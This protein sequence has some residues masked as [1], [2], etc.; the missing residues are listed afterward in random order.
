MGETVV[1][2]MLAL[3]DDPCTLHEVWCLRLRQHGWRSSDR[4]RF[5]DLVERVTGSDCAVCADCSDPVWADEV[6][7]VRGDGLVCES[8]VES[9]YSCQQCDELCHGDDMTSVRDGDYLVCGPCLRADWSYCEECEDYFA[10][11]SGHADEHHSG[12]ECESRHRCFHFPANGAGTV[13]NDTRL[14]VTL[15]SGV[16]D[17]TGLDAVNDYLC[18]A[19]IDPSDPWGDAA[20]QVRYLVRDVVE[21]VGPVWQTKQGNWPRR[22]SK[23]FHLA[24]VKLPGDT[25]SKVGNIARDHSSATSSWDL[26]L[27][28]DLNLPADDFYHEESCWWGGYEY[29]RCSLKTWGGIGLRTF[30]GEYDGVTGRAW[31][32]PLDDNMLPTHDI[33]GARAFVIFNGYGALEGYHA[34][35]LVAHLSSR[36]YRKISVETGAMYVNNDAG[37][38]VA[39]EATCAAYAALNFGRDSSDCHQGW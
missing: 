3:R 22:L 11:D 12:C 28:R 32:Q 15:P 33:G 29:S 25:L 20:Y 6:T 8:C 13:A 26:E 23:A 9:Y 38:L 24:G 34:A 2:A 30:S 21:S 17:E 37:Y 1:R 19:L 10:D 36:T 18:R 39:D 35:R 14:S 31:V 5:V 7:C 4:S 27:T 16:I